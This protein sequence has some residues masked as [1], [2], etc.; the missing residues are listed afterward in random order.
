MKVSIIIP[1]KENAGEF[2]EKKLR[3]LF[4]DKYKNFEVIVVDD[5]SP[6][7]AEKVIKNYPQV[8]LIKLK[9][10]PSFNMTVA[11]NKGAEIAKGEFLLFS[12]VDVIFS[13]DLIEKLVIPDNDVIYGRIRK[14]NGEFVYRIT[15]LA[16]IK[17]DFFIKIGGFDERFAGYY[18]YD[19]V[20]LEWKIKRFK[21][22]VKYK[23]E[24]IG[25]MIR[26]DKGGHALNAREL[27]ERNHKLF[28]SLI[29]SYDYIPVPQSLSFYPGFLSDEDI[30]ILGHFALDV[31]TG[32]VEIGSLAGKSARVF[33][34]F[35]DKPLICIDP[36]NWYTLSNVLAGGEIIGMNIKDA[37]RLFIENVIEPYQKRVK[38]IKKISNEAIYE[39]EPN[40]FDLLFID[41]YHSYEQVKNDFFN[42]SFKIK[43]PGIIIFHDYNNPDFPGIKQAVDEIIKQRGVEKILF[44]QS[45][46]V[47]KI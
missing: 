39:I 15:Y 46:A 8:K 2:L 23:E 6:F 5:S 9:N 24:V 14:Q 30:K 27:T 33:L 4:D 36:Y 16:L 13:S 21:G 35:S 3:C 37:E 44:T 40:S 42:Y 28:L 25:E 7:P 29:S 19:D 41:G 47:V 20:F 12:D 18:G 1:F 45:I 31:K 22:K 38:L 34:Y 11:R 26:F 43:K 17:K 32:I 10:S